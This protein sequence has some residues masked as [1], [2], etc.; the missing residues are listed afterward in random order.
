MI[1]MKGGAV[2][3]MKSVVMILFSLD[4]QLDCECLYFMCTVGGG[5]NDNFHTCI[6]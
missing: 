5:K 1:M 4:I 3:W 2:H 6:I